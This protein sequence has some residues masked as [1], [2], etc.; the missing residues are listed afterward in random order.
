M[1]QRR[2]ET[3]VTPP[4][5]RPRRGPTAAVQP[6]HQPGPA[7]PPA[8][9]RWTGTALLPPGAELGRDEDG[10]PYVETK[11]LTRRHQQQI[12]YLACVLR[13][14]YADRPDV[15][16]D[17]QMT[18]HYE[19]GNR[20]AFLEP[21]VAVVFVARPGDDRTSTKLWQ[22]PAPAFVLEVL[23]SSTWRNNLGPKREIYA[24]MGVAEYWLYDPY[25]RWMSGRLRAGRLREG[26]YEDGPPLTAP[27][28]PAA[29][30]RGRVLYSA[31]LELELLDADG[32][33]RFYDPA[34]RRYL[35]SYDEQAESADNETRRADREAERAAREAERADRETAA[36]QAAE[37]R[38]A[39][40]EAML[41]SR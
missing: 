24:A 7:R 5:G 30:H 40:L 12:T 25:E 33:L 37:A 27:A 20:N 41:R 4:I 3:A 34:A 31:A 13:R 28:A 14:R 21:D 16:V 9:G 18:V 17:T 38:I 11:P 32:H 6:P 36:R 26:V 15:S 19:E 1:L 8:A 35:P 29:P 22:E 2:G 39:E 10:Y 23:S